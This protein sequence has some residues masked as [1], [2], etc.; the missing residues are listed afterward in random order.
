MQDK[1]LKLLMLYRSLALEY[2]GVGFK[3]CSFMGKMTL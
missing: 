2:I 1:N 3:D